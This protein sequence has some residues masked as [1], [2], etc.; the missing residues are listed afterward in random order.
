[1]SLLN[2]LRSFTEDKREVGQDL[3]FKLII[4]VAALL[5]S[6][7]ASAEPKKIICQW[8]NQIIV[9]DCP[10]LSVTNTVTI[11][12]DTND[13]KAEGSTAEWSEWNCKDGH[14]SAKRLPLRATATTITVTKPA[15]RITS[16]YVFPAVAFNINRVDLSGGYDGRYNFEC[17]IEDLLLDRKI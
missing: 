11:T 16:S 12:L 4:A 7:C 14:S 1:M 13:L 15:K 8:K 2:K 10:S 17:R 5:A 6:V 3:M 9:E